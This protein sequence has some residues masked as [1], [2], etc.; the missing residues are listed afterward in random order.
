MQLKHIQ[1]V[2]FSP[3]HTSAKI[4]TMIAEGMDI[5]VNTEIDLTYPQIK[6]RYPQTRL[7]SSVFQHMREG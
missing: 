4:V 7:R 1:P 2:Y 6:K 5:M 3:T